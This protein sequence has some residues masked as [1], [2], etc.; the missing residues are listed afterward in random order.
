MSV[1]PDYD[2]WLER[3]YQEAYQAAE[4]LQCPECDGQMNEDRSDQSVE[5]PEC[6]Y[7]N[8]VDWDA[9][10]E[11]KAEVRAEARAEREDW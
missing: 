8:G 10:A 6:G 1:L 7:T 11:A 2:A 5:C 4:W 3:P 9:I